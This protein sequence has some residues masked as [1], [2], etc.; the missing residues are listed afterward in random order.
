MTQKPLF[1]KRPHTNLVQSIRM[2][3]S[4]GEISELLALGATYESAS[5]KTVG[6]WY[7]A[8]K[9]RSAELAK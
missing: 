4:N 1:T 5:L 3:Q 6:R 8:A 7:A 9:K 2:A